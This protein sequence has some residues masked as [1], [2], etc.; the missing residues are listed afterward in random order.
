MT[1]RLRLALQKSGRLTEGCFDLLRRCG[2]HFRLSNNQL[3][4]HCENFLLDLLM[5]RDEDIP[6]LVM[7]G[8]CDIGIV[9]NNILEE[10]ALARQ[11][12]DLQANYHTLKILPFASCDLM[13]ALPE[14][15][16]FS[17]VD[18]LNH[19]AIATSYPQLLNRYLKRQHIKAT[20]VQ[21]SGSV[22]IAPR[23][24]VADA[25]CDLVSTGATL[26][27]NGLRSVVNIFHSE[28]RLIRRTGNILPEQ[29]QL[30]NSF[31]HRLHG[32]L[33]A[34]ENKYVVLHAPKVKLQEIIALLPGIEHPTVIPLQ[35]DNAHVALHAVCHENVFWETM[36]A[37][38]ALGASAILV[39][40]IEKMMA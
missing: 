6:G 29:Q 40:P 10:V 8:L 15:M 4:C 18:D 1:E 11:E 27:S 39:L 30:L 7:Q 25:I 33:E 32:V 31:L 5:V 17:S 36:E 28:A 9:G 2:I 21:L 3:L 34:K 23:I 38:K 37:L 13:V 12:Q 24:G 35:H 19:K 22:E 14:D 20:V 26:E 16:P